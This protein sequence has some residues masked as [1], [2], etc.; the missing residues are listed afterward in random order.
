MP[1]AHPLHVAAPGL[2]VQI[3]AGR[4]GT[5]VIHRLP[6]ALGHGD[7]CQAD[8][9]PQHFVADGDADVHAP[10]IHLELDTAERGD[11]VEDGQRS[12]PAGGGGDLARGVQHPEVGLVM[13]EHDRAHVGVGSQLALHGVR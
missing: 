10:G 4:L 9:R 11:R 7:R 8:R 6:A 5:A 3:P 2:Q 13:N 1:V 12:V